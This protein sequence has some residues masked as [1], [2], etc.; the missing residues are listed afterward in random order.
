MLLEIISF[1]LLESFSVFNLC[2]CEAVMKHY[3]PLR[4]LTLIDAK[5]I[6]VSGTLPSRSAC[7]PSTCL[8]ISSRFDS[9]VSTIADLCSFKA[10]YEHWTVPINAT[11]VYAGI[12]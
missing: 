9:E 5:I 11:F 6:Y 8:D 3:T 10:L 2:S 12:L 1:F 7:L 4:H